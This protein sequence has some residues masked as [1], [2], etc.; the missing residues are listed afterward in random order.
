MKIGDKVHRKWKPKF[1]NGIVT[2][3]LGDKVMVKWYFDN[4]VPINILEERRH[5]KVIDESR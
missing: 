1:N 5:L 4:R 2:H 3:L